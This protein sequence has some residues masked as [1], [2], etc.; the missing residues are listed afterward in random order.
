MG[1]TLSNVYIGITRKSGGSLLIDQRGLNTVRLPGQIGPDA[2]KIGV[3]PR[4]IRI[5]STK[6]D[7]LGMF[8]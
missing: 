7:M 6:K 3:C 5:S 1:V 2:R 8:F 4:N